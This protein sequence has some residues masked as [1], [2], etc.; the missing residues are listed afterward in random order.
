MLRLFIAVELPPDLQ[1]KLSS[2]KNEM[3]K[4]KDAKWVEP[5]N[6]HLTL[7]FLGNCSEE[8]VSTIIESVAS[9]VKNA[10]PFAFKLNGLGCFPSN[11]RARV[12]W[13]GIKE[14]EED[15]IKLQQFVEEALK[16][17]GFKKEERA[18]HAHVTLARLRRPQ[19]M[20][21]GIA[22]I[23]TEEFST[24]FIQVKSITLFQS[25]LTPS[26][27]IYSEIAKIPLKG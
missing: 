15:L 2:V 21:L 19:D 13:I 18:F 12:F 7:K 11:K 8:K 24:P 23:E 9:C 16:P 25:R 22:S 27:P 4:V 6:L 5:Q 3:K 26:G 20:R 17:L 14:G 1:R 10:K